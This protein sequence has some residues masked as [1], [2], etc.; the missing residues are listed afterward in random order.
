MKDENRKAIVA[1][2]YALAGA[3]ASAAQDECNHNGDP[4]VVHLLVTEERK[5]ATVGYRINQR[6]GA[7]N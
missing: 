4:H 3:L 1:A 2:A 5:A 7:Q 6:F